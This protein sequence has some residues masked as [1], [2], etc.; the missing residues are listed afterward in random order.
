VSL[1]LEAIAQE[2]HIGTPVEMTSIAEE[3]ML[4]RATERAAS[5]PHAL[6][7]V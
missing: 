3:H 5:M 4:I 1:S 7:R 6:E 2:R